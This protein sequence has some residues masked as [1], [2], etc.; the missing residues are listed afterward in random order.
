MRQSNTQC[1]RILNLLKMG[2]VCPTGY[3]E[4]FPRMAARISE[5]RDAG[6]TI[7]T[8]ACLRPTHFH[9]SGRQIEYVLAPSERLFE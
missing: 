1:E 4:E 9:N 2:A 3:R 8:R 5:L 7:E 6:H